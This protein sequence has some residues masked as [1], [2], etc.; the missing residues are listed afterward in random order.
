MT[1]QSALNRKFIKRNPTKTN[2]FQQHSWRRFLHSRVRWRTDWYTF[3]AAAYIVSKTIKVDAL[4]SS[5]I[6]N[7]FTNQQG[8]VS[9]TTWTI[10]TAEE[11]HFT[12]TGPKQLPTS[13]IFILTHSVTLPARWAWR[14][15]VYKFLTYLYFNNQ[16]YLQFSRYST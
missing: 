5:E 14:S 8:V 7:I 12:R 9:Q 13:Y 2:T 4:I 16:N 6:L 3:I 11:T 1:L 10:N 15:F